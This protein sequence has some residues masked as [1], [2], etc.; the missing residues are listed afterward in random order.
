MRYNEILNEMIVRTNNH[1][2][3][4]N[5][6][7][8]HG[9]NIWIFDN[10]EEIPKDT[11]KEIKKETGLSKFT[12]SHDLIEKAE[13]RPDL[14]TAYYNNGVLYVNGMNASH[15]ATSSVL[16]KK[17]AD[18]LHVDSVNQTNIDYEGDNIETEYLRSDMIGD[19]PNIVYHGTSLKF[20]EEILKTG[21]R[22]SDNSNWKNVGKFHDLIFLTADINI[23]R[24][25]ANNTIG[26]Y[27]EPGVIIATKIPDRTKITI[28]YDV[29]YN[30]YGEKNVHNSYLP[31]LNKEMTPYQT[32]QI[33]KIQKHSPKT[34]FTKVTGIFAYKGAIT[35]PNFVKI[36]TNF[37]DE[38]ITQDNAYE[39][40]TLSNFKKALEMFYEHGFY[41]P[42]EDEDE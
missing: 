11:I 25:H 27:H 24:F 8:A 31:S 16:L 23:A 6:I 18:F 21:I 36:Y 29:A 38:P 40:E 13:N 3:T 5:I 41:D 30:F 19:I 15:H 1:L 35:P 34:D 10:N 14:L 4:S 7:L 2:T 37:S 17:V 32:K 39:F 22:P 12:N 9:A 33:K 26:K 20:I 42:D 28:D